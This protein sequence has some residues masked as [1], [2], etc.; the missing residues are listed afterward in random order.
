MLEKPEYVCHLAYHLDHHL[1]WVNRCSC[2][3]AVL[4]E[5]KDKQQFVLLFIFCLFADMSRQVYCPNPNCSSVF[6]TSR[7]LQCHLSQT[8]R[9]QCGIFA[10]RGILASQQNISSSSRQSQSARLSNVRSQRSQMSSLSI[11]EFNMNR[12]PNYS[13]FA[14]LMAPQAS[15]VVEQHHIYA[16]HEVDVPAA[17]DNAYVNNGMEDNEN[18]QDAGNVAHNVPVNMG[19]PVDMELDDD[20]FF[21]F[22]KHQKSIVHLLT[23]LESWNV[24]NDGFQAIVQWYEAS[25]ADDVSFLDKNK[26]RDANIEEIRRA[27]PKDMSAKL[28]PHIAPVELVG[29]REPVDLVRFDA[30][31]MIL[32]L[33]Q[34]NNLMQTKNLVINKDDPFDNFRCGLDSGNAIG[35]P[36]MGSVYQNYLQNEPPNTNDFQFELTMYLDR[37]HI[38]MNSRFTCCPL[39]LSS[40]LFNEK[41][42]RHYSFWRPLGYVHDVTLRSSA[43]NATSIRGHAT[44]N[45]H[46]QLA[47]LLDGICKI[48]TGEDTRLNNVLLTIDGKQKRVNIKVPILYF[49]ND[50]KEGDTL[51]CRV[52]SHNENTNCHSRVCD[53]RYDDML[54]VFAPCSMKRPGPIEQLVDAEDHEA[55]QEISQYCIPS[56]FRNLEFCD[57]EYGIFG[58]QPGDMLHMFQLGVIK[59]AVICFLDCFTPTQKTQL[60]D[61]GRRFNNRLKQSERRKFPRTDFSRGI[62]NTKQKQA[63]EYTGLLYVFCALINNH[64]AWVLVD[65]AL[66]KHELDIVKVLSLFE[67]LLCFDRWCRKATYWTHDDSEQ[68]EAIAKN[69]IQCMLNL[70]MDALPRNKG[71]G[72]ALSKMHDILHVPL[73]ITRFGC[74]LNCNTDFCEHNHKYQAKIPGR[75]A[76]KR[77]KTFTKSVAR[78]IVDAHVLQVFTDLVKINSNAVDKSMFD[79][80]PDPNAHDADDEDS[81]N[82]DNNEERPVTESVKYATQCKLSMVNNVLTVKWNT[83]SEAI[84]T[85][86]PGLARCI[87][88]EFDLQANPEKSVTLHTQYKRNE[89]LFRCHPNFRGNGPWYDWLMLMYTDDDYPDQVLSCPARLMAIVTVDGEEPTKYYPIV[90]WAGE[91]TFVDSVLFDEYNFEHTLDTDDPNSFNVHDVDSI[92]KRVF[93]IDCEQDGH[94]KILVAKDKDEWADLF[95]V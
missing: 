72:W 64:D 23:L 40:T 14:Q 35:E 50:A 22:T 78:N 17:G 36:R 70:L 62:T 26:T 59:T 82:E 84:H 77:H 42:R 69:A 27:I 46:R 29:F 25:R 83:R 49:M 79:T 92:E 75:R 16:E 93:V 33:L 53:I 2:F 87:V 67:C 15:Q 52:A 60:D 4:R 5:N 57:P 94:E 8:R 55:L 37:T 1:I 48:Q 56:C 9:R 43:E 90:Q 12:H 6:A 95:L 66:T 88:R 74:P 73:F 81:D 71:N 51:C 54:D 11:H 18:I 21:M 91:R 47:V 13:S 32:S 19:G 24:P 89:V 45:N 30:V 86:S 44:M 41:A 7:G 3:T 68:E 58:A 61:M 80:L 76:A 34:D 38:D 10:S 65:T 20:E 85:I 39:V 28:L 63:E 31:E